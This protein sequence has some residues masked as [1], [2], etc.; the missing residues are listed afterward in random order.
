MATERRLSAEQRQRTGAAAAAAAPARQ[1]RSAENP[2]VR[3]A[4]PSDRLNPKTVDPF[5]DSGGKGGSHK[6]AFAS[7]YAKGGVPCRLVHGSVKHKL[8][9]DAP[10]EQLPFDPV[11]V[12]LA[13]GIRE[14][15][16]PYTFVARNGFRELLATPGAQ[17]KVVPLL[18]KLVGPVRLALLH[19]SGD[20]FAAG[21]DALRQLSASAGPALNP[22]LK[23]LLGALVKRV[24]DKA[25]R[26]R[27]LAALQE[28]EQNG[29]R[30]CLAVIKS[31]VPTYSSVLT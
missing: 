24:S 17:V 15:V 29:G 23:G 21:L 22:H 28:L 9:W 10:P 19:A 6:S 12:T 18:G 16:H 30:E 4:R 8:S 3:A 13:E 7:V 25:Y 11:L 5:A 26:E 20:V 2:A 14:E 1:G 27:V 31:K